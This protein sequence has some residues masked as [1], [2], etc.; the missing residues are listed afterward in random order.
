MS[1]CVPTAMCAAPS[2]IAV[3]AARRSA[4][5]RP[6]VS[7]VTLH[8]QIA[9]QPRERAGVL[10][11]QDLGRRHQ[12]GLP[13]VLGGEQHREQR[14]DGFARADIALQQPVHARGRGHVGEDLAQRARL[15]AVS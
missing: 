8:R 1:A 13:A 5:G 15:R 10:L 6:P 4:A 7:S 3:S 12:S 2:A 14:D 11:G 9:E